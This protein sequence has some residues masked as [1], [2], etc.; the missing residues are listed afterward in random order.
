MQILLILELLQF[1]LEPIKIKVL[2]I[3]SQKNVEFVQL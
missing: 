2:F 1:Y 3:F